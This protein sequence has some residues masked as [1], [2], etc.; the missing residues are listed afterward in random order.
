MTEA[1]S[2]NLDQWIGPVIKSLVAFSSNHLHC[3]LGYKYVVLWISLN[4]VF[5]VYI[6]K[7]KFRRFLIWKM[8][9]AVF[10]A[11]LLGECVG[12]LHFNGQVD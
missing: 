6:D 5:F 10:M 11:C 2:S 8:Y 12:L 7:W 9:V 4:M 1:L 3:I